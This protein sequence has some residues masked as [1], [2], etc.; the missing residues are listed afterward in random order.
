[1]MAT[2]DDYWDELQDLHDEDLRDVVGD[3]I[4]NIDEQSLDTRLTVLN[5]ASYVAIALNERNYGA[6]LDAL[7]LVCD[8]L[9]PTIEATVNATGAQA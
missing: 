7:G 3:L 1:M 4:E 2:R 5:L 9:R 8:I 6:A